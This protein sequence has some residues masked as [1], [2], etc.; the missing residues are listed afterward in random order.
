MD[1]V[2]THLEHL[3]DVVGIEHVGIGADYDGVD[4]TPVGLEDVAS[5]PRLLG[6]LAGVGRLVF[7]RAGALAAAAA[8]A[9]Q[10]G[11]RHPE[12]PSWE[13]VLLGVRG[14]KNG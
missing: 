1:D 10:H 11:R 13:D 8:A 14:G 4:E 7:S 2:V 5:Y 3:R 12:M 6:A 9:G